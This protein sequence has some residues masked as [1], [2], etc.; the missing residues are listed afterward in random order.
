M[1]G[2]NMVLRI[3]TTSRTRCYLCKPRRMVQYFALNVDHIFEAD[4]CDAFDSDVD[5]APNVQTMF[6]VNLSSEDPIYDEAGLSHDSNTPFEVQDH[7]TFV[8]HMDE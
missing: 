7:D 4:Q 1:D 2:W 5:E 6:M 3:Q 8:D